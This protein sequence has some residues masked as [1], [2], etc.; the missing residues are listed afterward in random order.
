[1]FF[2]IARY[3]ERASIVKSMFSMRLSSL[4]GFEGSRILSLVLMPSKLLRKA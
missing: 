1:M 4:D 2:K 3:A